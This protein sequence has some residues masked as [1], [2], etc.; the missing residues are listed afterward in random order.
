[1]DAQPHDSLQSLVDLNLVESDLTK[2]NAFWSDVH[3]ILT[4]MLAKPMIEVIKQ[5]M[6]S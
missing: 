5:E 6:V 4:D 2:D 1:M 3:I